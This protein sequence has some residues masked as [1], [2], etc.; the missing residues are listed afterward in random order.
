MHN[1]TH[2]RVLWIGPA[3][4]AALLDGLNDYYFGNGGIELIHV[5]RPAG[6]G[7]EF[8]RALEDL[9]EYMSADGVASASWTARDAAALA[10]NSGDGTQRAKQY[11]MH[12]YEGGWEHLIFEILDDNRT[13][14]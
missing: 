4:S 1:T 13:Y 2:N 12:V 6:V 8:A 5:E 3:I 9:L 10:N 7:F 14:E 11:L